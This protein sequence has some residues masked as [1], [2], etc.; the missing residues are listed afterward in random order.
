MTFYHADSVDTGYSDSKG[1]NSGYRFFLMDVDGDGKG[2]IVARSWSGVFHT[3]LSNGTTFSYTASFDSGCTDSE[4]CG[5]G[6]RFFIMDVNGDGKGD[7]VTRDWSGV[8]NTWLSNGA[9]FFWADSFDSGYSDSKGWNSG[10]RFFLMDVN[11][12]SKGDIVARSWSGVFHT[13]LSVCL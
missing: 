4:G 5:S 8:L 6:H 7:I 12:D 3:W 1:W 11:G 9:T 10:Y 13:W 2:D